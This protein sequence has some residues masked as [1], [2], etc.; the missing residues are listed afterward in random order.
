MKIDVKSIWEDV[1]R[2]K[3]KLDSCSGP[4]EFVRSKNQPVYTNDMICTKCQGTLDVI[5]Y[6]WYKKGL[7]HGRKEKCMEKN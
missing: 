6:L 5:K 7:E 3:G 2:N 4:H 1:K